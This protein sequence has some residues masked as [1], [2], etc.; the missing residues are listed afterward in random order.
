MPQHYFLAGTTTFVASPHSFVTSGQLHIVISGQLHSM[1]T[2]GQLHIVTS[3]QLHIVTSGPPPTHV[4]SHSHFFA[5]CPL[6]KTVQTFKHSNPPLI[7]N[8]PFLTLIIILTMMLSRYIRIPNPN[9]DANC[10]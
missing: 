2:S 10:I 3:G 7:L 9:I 4:T 8:F 1:V 5:D 6:V